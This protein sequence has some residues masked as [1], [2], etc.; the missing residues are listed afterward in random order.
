VLRAY[1]PDPAPYRSSQ[2]PA[3]L[4][5]LDFSVGQQ[6]LRMGTRS[7]PAD[8][9][10]VADEHAARELALRRRL[11]T[12]QRPLVFAC[13][14]LAEAAAGETAELVEHAV[15]RLAEDDHPLVRAARS[16]QEDLCLMVHHHGAWHLEGAALCFPSLWLLGEKLGRPLSMVHEPVAHYAEELSSRVDTFFDRLAPD[17]VVWRRNF[18]IWPELWLWA[19]CTSFDGMASDASELWIRSER[20][21]LRR[22]PRSGA[23]LF[24]IRVQVTPTAVLSGRP[25]RAGDLAEWLSSPV[26]AERRRQLGSASEGLLARLREIA[27]GDESTI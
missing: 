13:T 8:Q 18:S 7:L 14:P 6:H 1:A 27:A 3:W 15:G 11:L 21:T 19:P 24:T 9:W 10:L 2:A 22:L 4:N 23:V 26:G 25:D 5:E 20:Q 17:R 12:E 16:V